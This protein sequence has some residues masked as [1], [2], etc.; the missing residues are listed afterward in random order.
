MCVTLPS[1]ISKW[2]T[3]HAQAWLAH[4]VELPQYVDAFKTASIDGHLLVTYMTGEHLE[5]IIGTV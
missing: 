3:S 4:T 1:N 2:R 5:E